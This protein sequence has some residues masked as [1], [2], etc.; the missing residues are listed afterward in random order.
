MFRMLSE[1]CNPMVKVHDIIARKPPP[2]FSRHCESSVLGTKFYAF[3]R[4]DFNVRN[5]P[6]N[7]M[8]LQY[9]IQYPI[10]FVTGNSSPATFVIIREHLSTT[11]HVEL[12]MTSH[13]DY[14]HGIPSTTFIAYAITPRNSM[15][16]QERATSAFRLNQSQGN[17]FSK[18]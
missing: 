11:L 9:S 10:S 6:Y 16:S 18:Q 13:D 8:V 4:Q 15:N 3:L 2:N 1:R 5:Q 17:H 7:I 12:S 14:H